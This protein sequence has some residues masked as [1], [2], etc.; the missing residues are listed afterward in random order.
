MNIFCNHASKIFIDIGN[1]NTK[2]ICTPEKYTIDIEYP[3]LDNIKI[4]IEKN[5]NIQKSFK[6]FIN[7]T[8]IN[9]TNVNNIYISC[10]ASHE[11]LYYIS[12]Q[13]QMYFYNANII[14]FN[15]DDAFFKDKF[16]LKNNYANPSL[17]GNDRWLSLLAAHKFMKNN[18]KNKYAVVISCGSATTIDFIHTNE[19][20][21]GFIIAGLDIMVNSLLTN[22]ANVKVHNSN[23]AADKLNLGLTTSDCVI[24]GALIAQIGF[25]EKSINHFISNIS[26]IKSQNVVEYDCIMYGG[27]AKKISNYLSIPHKIV[28]NMVI[29]GLSGLV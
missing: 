14:V 20:I 16:S 8:N 2:W 28:E 21:G 18:S 3:I 23:A 1:T 13:L 24:N 29:I 26:F 12:A 10:V 25:I 19:Y 27:N 17:L 15:K 22:T 9:H 11:Y 6:S 7:H 4:H 5:T